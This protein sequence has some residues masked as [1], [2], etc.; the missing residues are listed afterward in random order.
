[1]ERHIRIIMDAHM[2]CFMDRH[3]RITVD[4]HICIRID[5]SI[6][7]YRFHIKIRVSYSVQYVLV[8]AESIGSMPADVG[9][10]GAHLSSGNAA[11]AGPTRGGG[12]LGGR[13][14]VDGDCG[15]V[16]G[17]CCRVR[18]RKITLRNW[19]RTDSVGRTVPS[20]VV[21]IVPW[22]C[23]GPEGIG[24]RDVVFFDRS[25]GGVG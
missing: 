14:R 25:P 4:A 9:R 12:E 20:A 16:L 15:A 13:R 1:M 3:I 24:A 21:K 8:S 6:Y 18:K 11:A 5:G 23:V 2:C 22:S 17:G 19:L 7:S 10:I